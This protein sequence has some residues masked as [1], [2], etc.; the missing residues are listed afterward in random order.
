[1][2]PESGPDLPPIVVEGVVIGRVRV[3]IGLEVLVG[4][5]VG[6]S[7]WNRR[8][9]GVGVAA[10]ADVEVAAGLGAFGGERGDAP[11]GIVE[12]EIGEVVVLEAEL[13][14]ELPEGLVVVGLHG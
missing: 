8:C 4:V 1:M 7:S 13:I 12:G 10:D 5:A 2:R 14:G 6:R 3:R 9:S 11:D